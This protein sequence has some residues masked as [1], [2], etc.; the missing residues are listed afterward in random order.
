MA[1]NKEAIQEHGDAKLEDILKSIRGIIDNQ[2]Q[3]NPQMDKSAEIELLDKIEGRSMADEAEVALELDEVSEDY[4]FDDYE[5]ENV[6]ELTRTLSLDKIEENDSLLSE[7]TKNQTMAEFDRF[8]KTAQNAN[9][10]DKDDSLD[11]M[12]N[13]LMR[14]LVKEWLDSNLPRIVEKVVAEEIRKMV[15]KS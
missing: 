1:S 5:E 9:Y 14:P 4:S 7:S 10:Q 15:P 8:A 3:T 2:A 12:V 11:G 13:N 6:L